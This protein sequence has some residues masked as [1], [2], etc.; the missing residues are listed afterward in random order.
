MKSRPFGLRCLSDQGDSPCIGQRGFGLKESAPDQ[1]SERVVRT[2]EKL[3]DSI[4]QTSAVGSAAVGV[5]AAAIRTKAA[6][7]ILLV[8]G[9]P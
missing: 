2:R 5:D 9:N 6:N 3:Q 7:C 8:P 4:F 1:A